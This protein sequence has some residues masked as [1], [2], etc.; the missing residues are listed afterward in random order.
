MF[1]RI[2]EAFAAKDLLTRCS[3]GSSF[4]PWRACAVSAILA[5]QF[6]LNAAAFAATVPSGFVDSTY[7]ECRAMPRRW[8][9]RRTD[10]CSSASRAA[11]FSSCR[12]ATFSRRHFSR[13]RSMPPGSAGSLGVA[14]DPDFATNNFVYVYYTAKTPTIHNRVSRFTAN[15]NVAVPGSEVVLLDL[16]TLS[17]ATNHNGGAIHFGN[18]G[19]LYIAVGDNRQRRQRADARKPVRQDPA[20]QSRRLHPDGQSVRRSYV[21]RQS[22][23]LG[24]RAAQSVHDCISAQHWP[25]VHQRRGRNGLGGNQPGK[26]RRELRLACCRR[27]IDQPRVHESDLFLRPRRRSVCDNRRRLLRTRR[28]RLSHSRITANISSPTTARA[29]YDD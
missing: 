23:D 21:R 22:L 5:A 17:V 15:G 28:C 20:D 29:G 6:L 1:E 27:R 9:S 8:S 25:P 12:T 19:K 24:A 10:A 2:G 16:N 11:S 18:D 13:F 4:S 14:F 26:C 7:V 3:S